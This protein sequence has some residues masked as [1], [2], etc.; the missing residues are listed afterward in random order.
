METGI[1]KTDD[2]EIKYSVLKNRTMWAQIFYT[3][4]PNRSE[5]IDKQIETITQA[6]KHLFE[7]LTISPQTA[8]FKRFFSS[9]LINHAPGI[10]NYKKKQESDFFISTT[11]QPPA[12]N[13]KLCLFGMCLNNIVDESKQR[14]GDLFYFDTHANN[15]LTTHIFAEN[16]FDDQADKKSNSTTQTKNIFDDLQKK[17]KRFNANIEDNVLRTWIYAPHVDADYAGIVEARNKLFAEINLTKETH[18]I[19]ST[20][21]QGGSGHRYARVSMDAYAVSG[22]D[23]EVRYIRAPEHLCS[24]DVYGV[25]FERATAAKLGQSDFIFISGTASID[26]HGTVLHLGDVVKQTERTIENIIAL[27][28]AGDFSADDLT[29]FMVYLRDASDYSFVKPIIDK[30]FGNLPA[31]YLHAPVCRPDWLVEIEATGAKLLT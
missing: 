5:K 2:T 21:I 6:E 7:Y 20:G 16:L 15:K 11:E 3:I 13:V 8:A 27:L 10:A 23:I 14:A 17:L 22:E 30:T 9:D 18:Y 29:S 19:A 26:K 4:T 12:T 28:E 24:T 1:L 25:A 31:V